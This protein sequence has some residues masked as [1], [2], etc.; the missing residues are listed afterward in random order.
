[1]LIFPCQNKKP[2][3][4]NGLYD[5]G[6]YDKWAAD[7]PEHE[8]W[9]APCGAI[10]GFI[11]IDIDKKSG[12]LET[13]KLFDW[14]SPQMVETRGGGHHLFYKWGP[15]CEE[16]RNGVNVLPGIDVRSEG[17]YVILYGDI[18]PAALTPMPTW[19]ITMLKKPAAKLAPLP[20]GEKISSG[21]N[22]HLTRHAGRMQKIGVLNMAALMWV[23]ERDCEPPLEEEEVA[24]IFRNISRYAPES[25]P[26]EDPLPQTSYEKVGE[27]AS[28]FF[29]YISNDKRTGGVPTGIEGLDA[30]LGGGVR[31]GE[32]VG[33]LAQG[34]SGKSTLTHKIIFEWMRAEQAVGYASRELRPATEV[35]PNLLSLHYKQ[36][37]LKT[38]PDQADASQVLASWPLYFARGFGY[39]SL[40]EIKVWMTE[41]KSLGVECFVFDHL[42]HFVG[43]EDYK[44]IS[45][46]ARGIKQLTSELDVCTILVIQPKQIGMDQSGRPQKISFNSIR[47]GAAVAQAI[48]SLI[49]IERVRDEEGK[50]TDVAEVKVDIARH[51]LARPGS[52]WLK[53]DKDTMDYEEVE[54]VVEESPDSGPVADRG[55]NFREERPMIRPAGG[56]IRP[57]DGDAAARNMIKRL[58]I[59]R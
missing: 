11:V 44:L 51:K 17:G 16:I 4:P 35:V 34:K 54:P 3:T 26:D 59:S 56:S 1:M 7:Y 49:V 33:V 27:L 21:R 46:F 28:D 40:D 41:L 15:E 24:Q 32:V 10:N 39:F 42:I 47:G 5:A 9:A 52:I 55:R 2:L 38:P 58:N 19:L 6:P 8:E 13:M 48:D 50:L 25:T 30:M 23:N 37:V 36:N 18:D 29:S 12:G 31:P 14:G 22:H 43:D 20:E 45:T 57:V 53:Y